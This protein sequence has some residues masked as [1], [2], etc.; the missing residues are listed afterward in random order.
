MTQLAL[1]YAV[2]LMIAALLARDA[3]AEMYTPGVIL[4][5][6]PTTDKLVPM[7]RARRMVARKKVQVIAVATLLSLSYVHGY[8]NE[9]V[10]LIAVRD[11]LLEQGAPYGCL[12]N[13]DWQS[14]TW[15]FAARATLY[16]TN[17]ITDACALYLHRIRLGVWP[18]VLCPFPV[19]ISDVLIRMAD[20]AG[21][22]CETFLSHLSWATVLLL[23][24]LSV[25]VAALLVSHKLYGVLT[26]IKP[27]QN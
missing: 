2:I 10:R 27:K 4:P 20:G 1:C 24:L 8:V 22:A 6:P 15:W 25:T 11:A 9:L 21:L 12:G 5:H 16:D 13:R 17:T 7:V 3:V 18:N 19:V 14:T 23:V 26:P